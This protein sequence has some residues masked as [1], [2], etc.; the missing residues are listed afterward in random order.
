MEEGSTPTTRLRI[1]L[2]ADCW[3]KRVVSPV[4][5]LNCCQL[6]MVRGVLT[7]VI[8]PPCWLML[9]LPLTTCPPTGFA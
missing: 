9:A 7:T 2:L 5:M 4:P 8:T 1:A 6:T 3:T